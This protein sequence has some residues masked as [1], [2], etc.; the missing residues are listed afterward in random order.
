MF[1]NTKRR[2]KNFPYW[3]TIR[4]NKS[5]L[6]STLLY[7]EV[8]TCNGEQGVNFKTNGRQRVRSQVVFP[9]KHRWEYN[10]RAVG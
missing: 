3:R 10:G 6:Q 4:A 9:S 8:I 7:Y 1:L 5:E 2:H